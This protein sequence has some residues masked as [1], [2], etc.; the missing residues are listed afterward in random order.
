MAKSET[1][2]ALNV[3][4]RFVV[5][6]FTTKVLIAAYHVIQDRTCCEKIAKVERPLANGQFP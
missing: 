3:V 5:L 1:L 2:N 4:Y 6:I